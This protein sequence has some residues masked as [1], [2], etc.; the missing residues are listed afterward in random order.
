MEYPQHFILPSIFVII[1]NWKGWQDTVECIES[2]LRNDYKNFRVVVIDNH[3][4]DESY[5]K[6]LEWCRGRDRASVFQTKANLGFAGGNNVGIKYALENNAEYILLLNNDTVVTDNFLSSLT[7]TAKEEDP[8]IMGGKILYH[9]DD[10]IW[11]LGGKMSWLRGGAYHPGKGRTDRKIAKKPFEVDF[12]TGCMMLIKRDVFEKIG[13]LDESYFLYN[14]DADYCMK[15]FKAGIKMSVNPNSVIYHKERSTDGGW[16]PYHIYYLIRNK[17]IFMNRYV[18]NQVILWTFYSV[19]GLIGLTLSLKWF[20]QNRFDL[21]S[22]YL[23]A[24]SD[25]SKGIIGKTRC[26]N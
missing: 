2:L 12:I 7:K 10:R 13:F 8:G 11:Y 16:K 4:E 19:I 5:E 21:I 6:L 20:F 1:L 3:S 9:S 23:K 26:Y 25:Y 15:A 18:P 14:E 24:I 17:L 22:A